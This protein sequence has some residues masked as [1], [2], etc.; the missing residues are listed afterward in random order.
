MSGA[1]GSSQWMYSSGAAGFY[2]YSIDQSLRFN[3]DDNAYLKRDLTQDGNRK[4]YTISFWFKISSLG[5]GTASDDYRYLYADGKSSSTSNISLSGTDF[6][7][8]AINDGSSRTF[9]TNRLFRDVASFYHIVVAVDT[10]QVTDTDRVK[11]YINGQQETSFSLSSYPTKD[12]DTTI[13]K[14]GNDHLIGKYGGNT[15]RM[16]DGYLAE[17]H[18]IDG[19]ALDATSF[20]ET[21]NGV[22]VPKAYDTADGAYGTNGFYLPFDDSA[23]I[24]DDESGNTNDFTATN[25]AASDVVSDS[26]TNNFATYNPLAY[27]NQSPSYAE[28]NL[29]FDSGGWSSS[30]WGSKS[31]F[32]IPKDKKIYIE[33]E[34]TAI[35]GAYYAVGI[36]TAS[37]TPT[38]SNIGG[39]GSITL[40]HT[41][42]KINGTS[43]PHSQG[44]SSAGD[45]IGIAV[46]GSTGEVWFSRNGTWFTTGGAGADPSTGTDPIGTVTNPDDEDL[47]LVV[48]GNASANNLFVNFG[49]DST[50]V[51]SAES[52]A[53]GIGTFEYAVPTDHV[54]LC[55]SS[56]SEPVI[57]PNSAAG[58]ADDYFSAV[59]YTG[60]GT[61]SNAITGTGHQPDFLW[62]K[63]REVT[64]G[65]QLMDSVRGASVRLQS[66]GA[67]AE[68]ASALVSFDSD[69]FTV[70]GTTLNGTNA[71]GGSFV[72]WSWKAGGTSV[73]NEVGAINSQ[74]SAAPDA[75]FSIV[76][77]SGTLSGVGTASVGHGLSSRPEMVIGKAR[78]VTGGES[79]NWA[80][81]HDDLSTDNH[82]L[83]LDTNA[84]ESNKSGNGDMASLFT[85]TTFG[86]NYTSGLNVTGNNYV[87][88]CFHSVDG[89]SR[90]G[91]YR[92]NN[93]TDGTFVWTGFRPSWVM[94]KRL[95]SSTDWQILDTKRNTFNPMNEVLEPNESLSTRTSTSSADFFA[96]F[97]SNGFKLR[98]NGSSANGGTDDY[99][100][101][102]FGSSFKY[103]NAR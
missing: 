98:G 7:S 61:A 42:F 41:E 17:F 2:P 74:V 29:K 43:T 30:Y 77:Y 52:D 78:S 71:D 93:S 65:H 91:S 80:V 48:T 3:E 32:A 8:V 102:A 72:A 13:N 27:N 15:N 11:I 33:L 85:D 14:N 87:A 18:F 22:W 56:L 67:T 12:N 40:Y 47:F 88:Y 69:G 21:I 5:T 23:A 28:G 86:T 99:I 55:A 57:G 59:L 26:P 62:I 79:G 19:T 35:G 103:A 46:D 81:W 92:S 9:R 68:S 49:Q 1:F 39:T 38:S 36:G 31:T 16:W 4:T 6:L 24:G 58:Q 51:A 20:G 10:T 90:V 76:T 64:R 94:I 97:L 37:S 50:N 54:C 70:D 44:S 63:Q 96:D 60:D 66:H 89:F 84:D 100:Y 45:I 82:I 101:L 25:L 53:N 83:R 34:E 95:A 73:L 75:G